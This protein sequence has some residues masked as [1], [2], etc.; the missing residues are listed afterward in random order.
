MAVD[1][2]RERDSA[3]SAIRNIPIAQKF[4]LA[5]GLVCLLCIGLGSY[6][7]FAFHGIAKMNLEVSESSFPAVV[8]LAEMRTAID[9]TRRQDLALLLCTSPACVSSHHEAR[10]KAIAEYQASSK[11]FEPLAGEAA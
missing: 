4:V 3:M 2:G 11:L 7:F 5:F 8:Q 10:L 9:M 1:T 6:T